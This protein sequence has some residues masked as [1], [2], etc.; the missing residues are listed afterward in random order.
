MKTNFML[1]ALALL[2]EGAEGVQ[3]TAAGIFGRF[4]RMGPRVTS[5]L[6]H[7]QGPRV[8]SSLKAFQA[9]QV[10]TMQARNPFSDTGSYK[11]AHPTDSLDDRR[12]PPTPQNAD[13]PTLGT[14]PGSMEDLHSWDSLKHPD[15]NPIKLQTIEVTGDETEEQI[16]ALA[17]D[18]EDI[19]R[20]HDP[21]GPPVPRKGQNMPQE[22]MAA[23]HAVAHL[24]SQAS[25]KLHS[26][27]EVVADEVNRLFGQMRS[28]GTFFKI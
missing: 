12:E 17:A 9:G 15:R 25:Y 27:Q 7:L 14:A 16:Q 28:F 22:D 24:A 13:M 6:K 3:V 4:G 26:E 8:T 10:P 21:N 11:G 1:C 18:V 2:G 20:A 5:S 23:R 19:K